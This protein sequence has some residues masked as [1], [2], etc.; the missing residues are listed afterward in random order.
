MCPERA[1]ES[2]ASCRIEFIGARLFIRRRFAMARPF[3]ALRTRRSSKSGGGSR[4]TFRAH[5][6]WRA[7]R[8][9]TLYVFGAVQ[10]NP[11]SS[12]SS[13][14]SVLDFLGRR[15]RADCQQRSKIENE[16][17]KDDDEDDWRGAY[18]ALYTYETLS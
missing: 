1:P 6:V 18:T 7:P 9:E 12:S 8:V 4:A 16:N 5:F 15:K 10:G 13:S 11:Q 17:Y 2:G 14:S 3:P